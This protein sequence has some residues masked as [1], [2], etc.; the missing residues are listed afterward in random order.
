MSDVQEFKQLGILN[1]HKVHRA[2]LGNAVRSLNT[3]P[4]NTYYGMV[5]PF[6]ETLLDKP[7]VPGPVAGKVHR[8]HINRRGRVTRAR[9][10]GVCLE[11][12]VSACST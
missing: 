10:L 6:W 12:S 8:I 1:P 3:E 4:S 2:G 7:S 11:S 5:S 9:E